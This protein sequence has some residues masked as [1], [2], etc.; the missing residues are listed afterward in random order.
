M[1]FAEGH[2]FWLALGA[3]RPLLACS[4]GFVGI[5]DGRQQLCRE[6]YLAG[7]YGRA[8]N[9]NVALTAEMDLSDTGPVALP[10]GFGRSS[11]EAVFRV[12]S[13]LLSPSTRSGRITWPAGAPARRGCAPSTDASMATTRTAS[14]RRCCGHM[15][16]RL[17]PVA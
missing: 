8:A 7:L 11:A 17:I 4:V 3:S 12:R 5:S 9:G 6:G 16:A 15:K 13:T 1:L 2:G 14:A 10:L